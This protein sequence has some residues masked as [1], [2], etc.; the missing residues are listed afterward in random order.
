MRILV[1]EPD[2]DTLRVIE[3]MLGAE[4]FNVYG[5]DTA[6]E[7][8]D[9]GKLYDYDG[10]VL[11]VDMP[12]FSGFDVIRRLRDSRVKTPILVLSKLATVED[13]VR[14]LDLGADDFMT[15]PFHKDELV[16]RLTALVRRSKGE[17]ARIVTIGEV[18]LDLN[19]MSASVN[20]TPVHLT[21]K[22]YQILRALMLSTGTVQ[23]KERILNALYGG[24]DEPEAKIVDVFIC[25][26]RRKLT[27]AGAPPDFVETVWGR[28]YMV[29]KREAA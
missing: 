29:S 3:I 14:A 19:A 1:A 7:A 4:R 27:G 2:P 13:R 8:L 10:I 12:D 25:K 24:T 18:S 17:A 15:K 6:E 23:S 26:L 22:E 20:N 28:G 11:E 9:L 5:T 16:A 21:S